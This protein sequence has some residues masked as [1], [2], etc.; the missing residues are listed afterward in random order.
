MKARKQ[1]R[2]SKLVALLM[3]AALVLTMNITAFAAISKD[4]TG[5]VTVNGLDK[6]T[7][8]N[9]YK[10]I[11]VKVSDGGQPEEPMYKW[12]DSVADWVKTNGA[13]YIDTTDNSVKKEF[14]EGTAEAFKT[15]WQKMAAAIQ[16]NDIKL[17][18]AAD[19]KTTDADNSSVTFENLP[20][21]EYLITAAGGVKIY[22][23][24]TAKLV[25]V[26]DEDWKLDNASVVMKG[27]KPSIEKEIPDKGDQ[28]V[29]IGDTVSYKLTV[30]VPSY[31]EDATA[32]K[33]EVGDTMSAGLTFDADSLKV[34][35]DA[36]LQS[37]VTA[38]ESTFEVDTQVEGKTFVIRFAEQF[39]LGNAGKTIY[40]TYD[41]TVNN[42]A[43]KDDALGNSAFIGYNNDPYNN[44]SYETGDIEKDVYTYG[45]AVK[46][47]DKENNALAG[48]KFQVKDKG[49][50]VLKFNGE[51]GVYTYDSKGNGTVSEVEV[52]TDG[53]L[54]LEG[55]D[56]GAYILTE[57]K[58]PD[59]Y[60]VPTGTITV[61]IADQEPNGTIDKADVTTTGSIQVGEDSAVVN[62][63]V[64]SFNVV[65]TSADDAGFQLPTTGGMGTVMFT[66]CGILLMGG[67][68]AV[69]L[70]LKRRNSGC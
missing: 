46:K 41:A 66:V 30:T 27:E 8:V 58:A 21:G 37:E 51:N 48:A 1:T 40:V 18:P 29:A 59:G 2:M 44:D 9:I 33:F 60:V 17:A 39:T 10:V 26:Y 50:R 20:M 49:G 36:A 62:T 22:H 31:P 56:V 52:G 28:T 13:A 35:T 19:A 6:G 3:T 43:F 32:V 64:V 70:I 42:Q 15:F 63:N 65:N 45:I 67:A 24:T 4:T 14:Q 7:T 23:P 11:D 16:T 54:R 38:G 25:P 57:T 12:V 47:V 69:L 55:L 5:S 34:Y 61:V 53:T 68:V